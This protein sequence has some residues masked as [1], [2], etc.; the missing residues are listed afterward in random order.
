MVHKAG[1]KTKKSKKPQSKDEDWRIP[2]VK[3][4]ALSYKNI[5]AEFRAKYGQNKKCKE[6]LH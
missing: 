6:N 1:I 5:M 3:F 2:F 4:N